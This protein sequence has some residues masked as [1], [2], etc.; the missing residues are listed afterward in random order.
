MTWTGTPLAK[1]M[2]VGC[3]M[4]NEKDLLKTGGFFLSSV[5]LVIGYGFLVFLFLFNLEK[6]GEPDG[7]R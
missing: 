1:L 4:L 6:K 7:F 3:S 5:L 2:V